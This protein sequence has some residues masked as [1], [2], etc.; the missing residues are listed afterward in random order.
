[1]VA[2]NDIERGGN[3][4]IYNSVD[5]TL[6]GHKVEIKSNAGHSSKT[7]VHEAIMVAL[8]LGIQDSTSKAL[9]IQGLNNR[10]GSWVIAGGE[11]SDWRRSLGW[12]LGGASREPEMGARVLR[13]G[14]IA[15]SAL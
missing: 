13:S 15:G 4:L 1:M 14:V 9:A 5:P 12:G 10:S 8:S 7:A 3:T 11:N 2:A 6:L